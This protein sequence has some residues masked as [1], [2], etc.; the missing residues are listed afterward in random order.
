MTTLERARPVDASNERETIGL[1]D[2]SELLRA[3]ASPCKTPVVVFFAGARGIDE[4]FSAVS[5]YLSTSVEERDI[6]LIK[7]FSDFDEGRLKETLEG[8]AKIASAKWVLLVPEWKITGH[9]EALEDWIKSRRAVVFAFDPESVPVLSHE[10]IMK[11]A[12]APKRQPRTAQEI[13]ITEKSGIQLRSR[14][15]I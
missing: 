6:R 13:V 11:L 3:I 1:S 5:C 8:M 14:E 2:S 7:R 15:D 4:C 12:P 10:E 9:Y